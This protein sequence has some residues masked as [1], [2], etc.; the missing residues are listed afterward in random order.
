MMSITNKIKPTPEM[1]S[2]GKASP[3]LFF[4]YPIAEKI[5]PNNQ[6]VVPNNGIHPTKNP[7]IAN[8][9]PAVVN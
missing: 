2:P 5:T 1:M 7:I 3:F 6:T 8:T 9:N 4:E